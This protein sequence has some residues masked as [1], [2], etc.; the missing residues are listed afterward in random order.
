[1]TGQIFANLRITSD[2]KCI[3]NKTITI[4]GGFNIISSIFKKSREYQ[5]STNCALSD[6]YL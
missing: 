6:I 1:M 2:E 4:P 5:T 3:E